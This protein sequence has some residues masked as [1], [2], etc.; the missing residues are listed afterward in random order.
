MGQIGLQFAGKAVKQREANTGLVAWLA[1]TANINPKGIWMGHQL[2]FQSSSGQKTSGF[3]I[4]DLAPPFFY[5]LLS[6]PIQMFGHE[7]SPCYFPGG[8]KS[9]ADVYV[10]F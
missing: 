9:P 6:E 8:G 2:Y 1:G 3:D 5:S 10:T 4:P 7:H